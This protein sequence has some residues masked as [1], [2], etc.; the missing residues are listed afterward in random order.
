MVFQS[1]GVEG[2]IAW[3][4]EVDL[5]EGAVATAGLQPANR[6]AS[7]DS[8]ATGICLKAGLAFL[9]MAEGTRVQKPCG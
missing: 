4:A 6:R 5:A 9:G 2:L 8:E 1:A 3:D 7:M